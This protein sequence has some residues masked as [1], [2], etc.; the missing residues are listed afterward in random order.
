MVITNNYGYGMATVAGG[1]NYTIGVGLLHCTKI[2]YPIV[3]FG[4]TQD[5]YFSMENC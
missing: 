5:S 4:L 1:G 3:P 2:L